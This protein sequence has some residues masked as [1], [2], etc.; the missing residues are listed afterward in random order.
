MRPNWL[1]TMFGRRDLQPGEILVPHLE[2]N[3]RF[4]RVL[5]DAEL[6]LK[7][8]AE[9]GHEITPETRI[10]ILRAREISKSSP[11]TWDPQMVADLLA[12]LT[13][14]SQKVAPVTAR[15]L[16]EYYRVRDS[17]RI[18]S[19]R[20]LRR[21]VLLAVVV[22]LVSIGAFVTSSL[23][24]EM[25]D[26]ITIANALAVK[27]RTEVGPP[28]AADVGTKDIVSDLQEYA[29]TVRSLFAHAR[30]LNYFVFRTVVIPL[31]LQ[32]VSSGASQKTKEERAEYLK[33]KFELPP[34]IPDFEKARDDMTATYQD[35]RYFATKIIS[36]VN[37]VYG[38]ISTCI[39]PMFY[40]LL[41]TCAYLLLNYEDKLNSRT[42]V[43]SS[44]DS[45]RF[46]VAAIGGVVLG[47]FSNV[48][49]SDK[50]SIPPLGLAFL[51]GYAVDVFFALLNGVVNSFTRISAA[52][53][54]APPP[55]PVR[56]QPEP[57]TPPPPATSVPI[58]VASTASTPAATAAGQVP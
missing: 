44:G 34:G 40:A 30:W 35:V 16:R 1:K 23:S 24:N 36:D 43:P 31:T 55:H 2:P 15:S 47:L 41:G 49:V 20:Y 48:V 32:D 53:A 4:R 37:I 18:A 5:D 28:Q 7:Y 52:T 14:L 9:S 21:T 17:G 3:Y 27:L 29:A 42:Y 57:I 25:R 19:F 8:A 10:R 54:A 51:V 11:E 39:L 56:T 46:V 12:G 6:L 33:D 22:V 38:A 13:E 58:P 50:A 45:A 26:E